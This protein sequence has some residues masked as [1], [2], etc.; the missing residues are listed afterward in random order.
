MRLD[1]YGQ[2]IEV[3][4]ADDAWRV[5]YVGNDGTKRA[6]ADIR[7]PDDVRAEDIAGYLDDLCHERATP[8]HPRVRRLD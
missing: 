4:R 1:L 2:A 8:A 3:D 6:A 5:C 7:I